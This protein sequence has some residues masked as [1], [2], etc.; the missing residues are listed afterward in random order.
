MLE[1]RNLL[2]SPSCFAVLNGYQLEMDENIKLLIDT[3]LYHRMRMEYGMPYFVEDILIANREHDS[4][5]SASGIQYDNFIQHPEGGWLINQAEL[6]YV[7]AKH[8]NFCI[9]ERKYPDEN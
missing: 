1:G 2:G 7:E 8:K 6:D 9:N 4:R 3:E 5:M